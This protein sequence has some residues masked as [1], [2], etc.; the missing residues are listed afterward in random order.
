[1]HGWRLAI[2]IPSYS[3]EAATPASS[4]ASRSRSSRSFGRLSAVARHDEEALVLMAGARKG[5]AAFTLADLLGRRG[6]ER[7]CETL[8]AGG[9]RRRTYACQPPSTTA[10]APRG[11]CSRRSCAG[12]SHPYGLGGVGDIARGR[13]APTPAPGPTRPFSYPLLIGLHA[14]PGTPPIGPNMLTS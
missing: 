12:F 13:L 7:P 1:M 14:T 9:E 8:V 2:P 11:S 3:R 10:S 6:M 4:L 5:N